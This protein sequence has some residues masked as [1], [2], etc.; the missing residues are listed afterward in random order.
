MSRV[1]SS[2]RVAAALAL[3]FALGACSGGGEEKA[4]PGT[5]DVQS[6]KAATSSKAVPTV[7][8]GTL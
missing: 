3:V 1:A 2:S 7:A 5:F 6:P 8:P 4:G